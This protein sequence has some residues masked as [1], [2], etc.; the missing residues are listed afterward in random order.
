MKHRILLSL[1][2]A[3]STT[4]VLAGD[5]ELFDPAAFAAKPWD[6]AKSYYSEVG[7]KNWKGTQRVALFSA[8]T[9]KLDSS[10]SAT[11]VDML[12]GSRTG[13]AASSMT[14]ALNGVSAEALQRIA[15]GFHARLAAEL[16]ALG[17]TVIPAEEVM[18][19]P[20]Y[21]AL[22]ALDDASRRGPYTDPNYMG[23]GKPARL[24]TITAHGQPLF[25]DSGTGIFKAMGQATKLS[26]AL[27]PDVSIVYANPQIDFVQMAASGGLL[28][29]SAKTSG[30]PLLQL[31]TSQIGFVHGYYP[32][33]LNPKRPL[34]TGR[35]Y[36]ATVRKTGS[37]DR[38]NWFTGNASSVSTYV[39]DAEE[40]KYEEAMAELLGVHAQLFTAYLRGKG[41]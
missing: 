7:F 34:I 5:D 30:K 29:R 40:A 13:T 38:S 20:A 4:P 27:G 15:D 41:K 32:A 16:T 24:A 1:I 36:G 35:D 11:A 37:D 6:V 2:A 18:A 33:G 21:A 39:V 12:G 3:L 26:Q 9:F 19:S 22:A 10:I 8:V 28:A 25:L 14:M 17:V 31:F 23:M